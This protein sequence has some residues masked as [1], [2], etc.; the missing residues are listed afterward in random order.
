MTEVSDTP[1]LNDP[2]GLDEI[3]ENEV[4]ACECCSKPRWF[5][6]ILIGFVLVAAS[7]TATIAYAAPSILAPVVEVIPDAWLGA[8]NNSPAP[9]SFSE[10]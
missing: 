3:L 10:C 2:Q 6:K 4:L 5:A 9:K 7:A 8:E 1:D